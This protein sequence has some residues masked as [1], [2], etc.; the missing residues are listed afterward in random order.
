M[1]LSLINA[2]NIY[3]KNIYLFYIII[4]FV[5]VQCSSFDEFNLNANMG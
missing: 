2:K 4:S 3:L 1:K 5:E